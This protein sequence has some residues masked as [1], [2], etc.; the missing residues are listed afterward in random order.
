MG[1]SDPGARITLTHACLLPSPNPLVKG[2]YIL[3]RAAF[4]GNVTCE[5][6]NAP[7]GRLALQRPRDMAA[8]LNNGGDGSSNSGG[9][10]G[11]GAEGGGGRNDGGNGRGVATSDEALLWAS[12]GGG[13]TRATSMPWRREPVA[14][15]ASGSLF[16]WRES[17]D[18]VVAS[19]PGPGLPLPPV[20]RVDSEGGGE[21]YGTGGMGARLTSKVHMI[22]SGVLPPE[23]RFGSRSSFPRVSPVNPFRHSLWCVRVDFPLVPAVFCLRKSFDMMDD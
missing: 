21:S 14:P 6:A 11:G 20:G 7:V 22:G 15:S 3:W 13:T 9:S 4:K 8:C 5:V 2:V 19:F 23:S 10:G 17:T 16:S 1:G 18:A 12:T